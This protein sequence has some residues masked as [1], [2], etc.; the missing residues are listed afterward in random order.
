MPALTPPPGARDH[1]AGHAADLAPSPLQPTRLV[2]DL[3]VTYDTPAIVGTV[4]FT[5]ANGGASPVQDVPLLL[6]RLMRVTGV[7]DEKGTALPVD[8]SVEI[9]TDEPMWQVRRATVHLPRPLTAGA[10]ATIEITYQGPLVGYTEVGW[11]YVKDHIDPAFTILREEA[12]AFPKVGV[13]CARANDAVAR[14]PF[15]FE[16]RVTVPS[17]EVV[18]TGGSLVGRRTAPGDRVTYEFRGEDL[19]FLNITI[20]PY[21]VSTAGGITVYALPDDAQRAVSVLEAAHGALG[22]LERWY[23][24]LPAPPHVPIIEIPEGYG[25]QAS[26]MGG[27]ILESP[28]FSDRG[29]RSDLYHELS[30]LWNAPDLDVPSPRWNE[31]LAVYLSYR[32]AAELDGSTGLG[33]ALE[34]ARGRL[35]DAATRDSPLRRTPFAS[36]GVAGQTDWSY[37]LG[38]LMFAAL[39]EAVG[40]DALDAGLRSYFQDSVQKGGTT[41]QLV[42][43]IARG[44][45]KDVRPFFERWMFTAGWVDEVCAHRPERRP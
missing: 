20:A 34:K 12:L 8:S 5:L 29:R 19:P 43:T 13:L 24:P 36:Y 44:T 33:A 3:E 27:I 21:Q 28:V 38:F 30:H 7:R 25:S 4:T 16:A 45:L 2:L 32:L 23:G 41:R 9:L 10:A 6:N 15:G 11:R 18:A 22:L 40:R 14:R 39:E 1:V 26:L 37:Q 31:G 35:C 42:E 17:A